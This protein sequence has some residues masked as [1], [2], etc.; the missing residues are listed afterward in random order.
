MKARLIRSVAPVPS[1]DLVLPTD[2]MLV[3]E[4]ERGS[5]LYVELLVELR[6]ELLEPLDA[7]EHEAPGGVG[8]RG[9]VEAHPKT[10]FGSEGGAHFLPHDTKSIR[11]R[12]ARGGKGRP[13]RVE[14]IA[15][16]RA[17]R[18]PRNE[19]RKHV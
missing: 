17:V 6:P 16:I 12:L 5:V 18:A 19:R 3:K 7:D 11:P 9:G 2:E 10:S 13:S 8:G 4:L 15:M 1:F 14:T